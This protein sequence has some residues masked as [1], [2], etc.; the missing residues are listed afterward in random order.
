MFQKDSDP[1]TKWRRQLDD[2]M[3]LPDDFERG[4]AGL[5]LALGEGA[6]FLAVA[7]TVSQGPPKPSDIE[8]LADLKWKDFYE[9]IEAT[10]GTGSVRALAGKAFAGLTLQQQLAALLAVK[11]NPEQ[12]EGDSN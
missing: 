11:S 1:T 10:R 2:V 12:R 7:D 8:Q 6:A 9:H 5:Q 4:V 3:Q